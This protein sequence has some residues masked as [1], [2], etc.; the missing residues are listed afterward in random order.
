MPLSVFAVCLAPWR[1]HGRGFLRV[2][3]VR[4]PR[5]DRLPR[6]RPLSLALARQH[7]RHEVPSAEVLRSVLGVH[8]AP[9]GLAAAE[10]SLAPLNSSVR[11]GSHDACCEH[12]TRG[13]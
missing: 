3:G 11:D 5:A 4:V 2:H 1:Y 8:A 6:S 12:H 10:C 13:L 7:T 9:R